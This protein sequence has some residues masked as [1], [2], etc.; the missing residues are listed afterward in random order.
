MM[1]AAPVLADQAQ[2]AAQIAALSLQWVQPYAV[3]EPVQKRP[4]VPYQ[5]VQVSGCDITI[6]QWF[7]SQTPDQ[8]LLQVRGD[9]ARDSVT[10]EIED[11]RGDIG[12]LPPG[13]PVFGSIYL[14]PVAGGSITLGRR[15]AEIFNQLSAEIANGQDE[16]GLAALLYEFAALIPTET[17]EAE[18]WFAVFNGSDRLVALA[19]EIQRYA[20]RWCRYTS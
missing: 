20:D 19:A 17:E 14:T 8:F 12:S 16:A 3:F 7:P 2:D 4:L 6:S 13:T 10:V 11:P 9:L 15:S 18:G 1:A 5:G